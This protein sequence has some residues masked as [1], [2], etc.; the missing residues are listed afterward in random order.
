MTR[1][2]MIFGVALA[3]YGASARA[4][5]LIVDASN[6]QVDENVLFNEADLITTGTTAQGVTNT[7]GVVVNFVGTE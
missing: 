4:D 5:I 6:P 7:S 2:A 1:L 3:C